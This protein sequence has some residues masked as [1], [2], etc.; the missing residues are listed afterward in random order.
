MNFQKKEKIQK[1]RSDR[2]VIILGKENGQKG[3][4][5]SD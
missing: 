5:K 4:E 2:N 3:E 1:K